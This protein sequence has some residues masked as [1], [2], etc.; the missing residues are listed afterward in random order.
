MGNVPSH[1]RHRFTLKKKE[2]LR[3]RTTLQ[4]LLARAQRIRATH[5]QGLLLIDQQRATRVQPFILVGFSARKTVKRAVDRNRIKRLMRESYR[6]NKHSLLSTI[7]KSQHTLKLLFLYSPKKISHG[8][9][10]PTYSEVE[11]DVKHIL[12][13]VSTMKLQ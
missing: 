11:S 13:V 4:E 5:I 12:D 2:I 1:P 9:E 8:S 7:E 6:L 10:L 3:G